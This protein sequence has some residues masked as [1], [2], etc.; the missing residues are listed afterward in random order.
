MYKKLIVFLLL[1]LGLTATSNAT[2]L[3]FEDWYHTGIDGI[4]ITFN[5]TDWDGIW[6][7]EFG[8][9]VD[10]DHNPNTLNTAIGEFFTYGYCVDFGNAIAIDDK[11]YIIDRFTDPSSYDDGSYSSSGN[12][13]YAA[14][15]M[16]EYSVGFGYAGYSDL[17]SNSDE[18]EASAALQI[19]IW[20]AIYNFDDGS[21]SFSGTTF[22]YSVTNIKV[23]ALVDKY[24]TAFINNYVPVSSTN[25]QYVVAELSNL[26]GD[27]VQD[28]IIRVPIPEPATMLLMGFGL[29]G[30]AGVGARRRKNKR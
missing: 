11:S 10:V 7:G 29:I 3:Y 9:Q 16:D 18:D 13:D 30:L 1:L 22:Q 4:D 12:G 2:Q 25:Y 27:D 19:A 8:M 20:D 24:E 6:A 15:F 5:G 28:V 17:V 14:W 21:S 23:G 26:Q